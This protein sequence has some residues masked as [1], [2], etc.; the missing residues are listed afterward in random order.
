MIDENFLS[1]L[2]ERSAK[3]TE[4]LKE[5]L[6]DM[7]VIMSES[8][9]NAPEEHKDIVQKADIL[10]KRVIASAMEGNTQEVDKLIKDFKDGCKNNR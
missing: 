8:M 5:T 6:T 3:A 9:K 4:L 7:N 10:C 2:V 1:N